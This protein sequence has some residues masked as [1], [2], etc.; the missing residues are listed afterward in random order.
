MG[1]TA[2]LGAGMFVSTAILGTVV[3]IGKEV[4]LK[5]RPFLRDIS[6]YAIAITYLLINFQ[7]G[8]LNSLRAGGF[9]ILYIGY[10]TVAIVSHHINQ[11]WKRRRKLAT[12]EY[13]ELSESDEAIGDQEKAEFSKETEQALL[14]DQ[15][16][17]NVAVNGGKSENG[18]MTSHL[19][20]PNGDVGNNRRLR[21]GSEGTGADRVTSKH[22][23]RS[24]WKHV[25]ADH[26]PPMLF[27]ESHRRVD[28]LLS[29][30]QY[31]PE[32]EES[33]LKYHRTGGSVDERMFCLNKA[34]LQEGGVKEG[35]LS[36]R[37]PAD[38][39][40]LTDNKEV[41]AL[42]KYF[43]RNSWIGNA[44]YYALMPSR[45]IRML[46]VPLVDEGTYDWRYVMCK[47]GY[48]S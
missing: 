42:E 44:L 21:V 5:R 12:A 40:T 1:T 26:P 16:A 28:N 43:G 32:E 46:S 4:K 34:R 23:S 48:H 10:A 20:M 8:K 39:N 38:T 18:H 3:L 14:T 41:S 7:M 47:L 15:E 13:L 27:N 35:S 19:G 37:Q 9:M 24:E 17:D 2:I 25:F 33:I 22:L 6:A 36:E 11:R 30:L 31:E 29:S 45:I